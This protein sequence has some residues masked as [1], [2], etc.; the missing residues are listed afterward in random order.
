[1]VSTD[2]RPPTADRIK[3]GRDYYN[4]YL[5]LTGNITVNS[6]SET[7][8]RTLSGLT[9]NTHYYV[10]GV[11][12]VNNSDYSEIK[13]YN[14]STGTGATPLLLS[15]TYRLTTTTTSGAI[16]F[17][18]SVTDGFV[19]T[20]GPHIDLSGA[21]KDAGVSITVTKTPNAASNITA[22]PPAWVTTDSTTFSI[23]GNNLTVGR[24]TLTLTVTEANKRSLTYTIYID[25][26]Q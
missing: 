7:Y 2:S 26:Q 21:N 18:H 19:Y 13:T 20:A 22:S 9:D 10:F 4:N 3:N 23:D 25:K 6:A 5:S 16:T 24:N 15:A 8:Q 1:V 11:L 17:T 14:F 12:Y